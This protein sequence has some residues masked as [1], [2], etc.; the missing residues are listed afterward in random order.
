MVLAGGHPRYHI[1]VTA[2]L[3]IVLCALSAYADVDNR[4][5]VVFRSDDC[6]TDW[7]VPFNG[8]G[9]MSGLQYG[10]LKHIPITWAVIS[11][12]PGQGSSFT[13]AQLRAYLDANGG[14]PAS[15]S[16]LHDPMPTEQGYVDEVV[17]SKPAIEANLPGYTCNTFLQPGSWTGEGNMCSY[18]QLDRPTGQAIR[19]TYAQSM[20]YLGVGMTIGGIYYRYGTSNNFSIDYQSY[21]TISGVNYLLDAVA[22]TPGLIYVISGHAVQETGKTET[23]HINAEILKATMDKLADLR[24]QGKIRLMSLHEAF[25]TT[26]STN[27]N[28][29]SDPNFD[30]ENPSVMQ[31]PWTVGGSAQMA[32]TGGVEDSRF[33][34]LQDSTSTLRH[35]Q[36]TLA[37]G[38]YQLDWYQKVVNNKQNSG[39]VLALTEY[40]ANYTPANMGA[41]W[42]FFVNNSP[43]TWE[44][45]TALIYVPDKTAMNSMQFQPA[46]NGGYGIDS[47]SLVRAPVDAAVSPSACAIAPSP[48]QCTLSWHTPADAS[49]LN[50]VSRYSSTTHPLTPTTGTSFSSVAAQPGTD[51]QVTVPINWTTQSAS[52]LYF[53][54][55]GSKSGGAYTP[56][57]IMWIKIDKTA[58]STPVVTASRSTNGTINARWSSYEPD[59]QIVQYKYAVGS[60]YGASDIRPWATTSDAS[61][62]ITGVSK[63]LA[64]YVSVMAENQFGFWSSSG[65]TLVSAPSGI[66]GLVALPNG[67]T[68]CVTG[69]VTAVFDGCYYIVE[70]G[71][72]RGIRVVG[73]TAGVHEGD[74]VV[75]QGRLNSQ[76]G[77]RHIE[78]D[79]E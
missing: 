54:V 10:T 57:D 6:S 36:L 72:V 75:V 3:L 16:I 63:T 44:K 73:P 14:E 32:S 42:A 9:G 50:V 46:A 49:V 47:V 15:H 30:L 70:S 74:S 43:N 17:N 56:P 7:N 13:W 53:S 61:A 66:A 22:A 34:S 64:V 69:T 78:Q 40:G 29:V 79:G 23:Y 77:E 25:H 62:I 59:S 37:P 31:F 41:N 45:K 28:C 39:L 38:R 19:A 24:D 60:S 12:R 20:A 8:L 76:N 48:G 18:E 4:P 55:F 21:P 33:C 35:V 26:F 65:S 68:V 71:G 27:L 1:G 5:I 58:P 51:Q 2:L 52:Y 67:S 11:S